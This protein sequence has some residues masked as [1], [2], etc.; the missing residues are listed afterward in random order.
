MSV[1]YPVAL[2]RMVSFSHGTFLTLHSENNTFS[3]NCDFVFQKMG[4]LCCVWSRESRM[5]MRTIKC[6]PLSREWAKHRQWF[7][8]SSVFKCFCNNVEHLCD[9]PCHVTEI[10]SNQPLWFGQYWRLSRASISTFL[11]LNPTSHLQTI[12]SAMAPSL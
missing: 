11:I 10:I 5:E 9:V 4:R 1:Q 6:F 2:F 7:T 8:Y 3:I 12:R